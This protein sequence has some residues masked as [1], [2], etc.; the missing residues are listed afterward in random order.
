MRFRFLLLVNV[1]CFVIGA[2][3]GGLAL[4]VCVAAAASTVALLRS[5]REAERSA[6]QHLGW[7]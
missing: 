7:R 2:A 5:N 6:A 3:V 4:L 1:F